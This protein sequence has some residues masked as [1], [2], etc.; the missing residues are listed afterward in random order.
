MLVLSI[1]LCANS[2]GLM[3]VARQTHFRED[4]SAV[5]RIMYRLNVSERNQVRSAVNMLFSSRSDYNDVKAARQ[6][7][8]EAIAAKYS[9]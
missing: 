4:Y 9:A 6:T 7:I 1:C 3:A 2:R 5:M 8:I